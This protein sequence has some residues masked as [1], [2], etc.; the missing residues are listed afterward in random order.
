MAA[1]T[2]DSLERRLR[3]LML[4]PTTHIKHYRNLHNAGEVVWVEGDPNSYVS[5]DPSWR[6]EIPTLLHELIHVELSLHRTWGALDEAM[7]LGLEDAMVDRIKKSVP[8][9][10]WWRRHLDAKLKGAA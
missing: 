9:C 6:G 1:P 3:R 2:L 10:K 4:A 7:V 5:L 8:R